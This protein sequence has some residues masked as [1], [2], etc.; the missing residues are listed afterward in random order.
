MIRTFFPDEI[1]EA[2][3]EIVDNY[4]F[5]NCSAKDERAALPIQPSKQG[6][7]IGRFLA[8]WAIF[9]LLGDF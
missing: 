2:E 4:N 8:S 9:R 1:C 3:I 5:S 7:Q 6:K